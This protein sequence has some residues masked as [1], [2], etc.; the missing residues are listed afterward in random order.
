MIS[1]TKIMIIGCA[2]AV[3][4]GAFAVY[5]LNDSFFP[6]NDR[7]IPNPDS[8][9]DQIGLKLASAHIWLGTVTRAKS[10][11]SS[12]MVTLTAINT[13]ISLKATKYLNSNESIPDAE[14]DYFLIEIYT[15]LDSIKNSSYYVGTAYNRSFPLSSARI[16]AFGNMIPINKTLGNSGGNFFFTWAPGTSK[17][18]GFQGAEASSNLPKVSILTNSD[19]LTIRISRL[20]TMTISGNSTTYTS[21]DK[22]LIQQVQLQKTSNG[23]LY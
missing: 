23:F 10:P 5:P 6:L 15:E 17:T 11:N 20:G 7:V 14:I 22:T 8:N 1:Q 2:I 16:L 19:T 3:V 12:E 13:E 21:A 4:L 18:A 9:S